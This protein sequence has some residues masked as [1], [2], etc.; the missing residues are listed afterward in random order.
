MANELTWRGDV[1]RLN[2]QTTS[3]AANMSKYHIWY[4]AESLLGNV[5]G[6][7]GSGLWTVFSSSNGTTANTS[8][9]WGGA[10][11]NAANIVNA[12][13]AHSWMT[14]R[15]PA[16]FMSGSD[17]LYFTI[18]CNSATTNVATFAFSKTAPT[19]SSITTRGGAA[20]EWT[21]AGVNPDNGAVTSA[22]RLSTLLSTRGDFTLYEVNEGA[23]VFYSAI[24][25]VRLQEVVSADTVPCMTMAI[26]GGYVNGVSNNPGFVFQAPGFNISDNKL[27][28]NANT[29]IRTRNFNNTATPTSLIPIPALSTNT[30]WS[31]LLGLNTL[32]GTNISD[33]SY[34]DFPCYLLNLEPNTEKKGRLPDIL[35]ASGAP[36]QGTV[37]PANAPYEYQKAGQLWLPWVANEPPL[38]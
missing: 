16:S 9:N 8:D 12:V 36:P 15:S 10:T 5:G 2:P 34:N 26:F 19:G 33:A 28:G 20:D 22:H 29:F 24:C 23:G 21:Y 4:M 30:A 7:T 25:C 38:L 17:Y 18:D 32:V 31:A 13:G 11:F 14:L 37:R 1:N 35:I 27:A 6:L 3:S